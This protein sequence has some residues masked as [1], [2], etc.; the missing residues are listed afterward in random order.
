M[1]DLAG[2]LDIP[3]KVVARH[4]FHDFVVKL[5]QDGVQ[6]ERLAHGLNFEEA[7]SALSHATLMQ[8]M[9]ICARECFTQR[10]HLIERG[11]R[12]MNLACEAETVTNIKVVDCAI[13]NPTHLPEILPLEPYENHNWTSEQYEACF[14]ET[15]TWLSDHAPMMEICGVICDNLP[16]QVAGL[17]TFLETADGKCSAILHI[18]CVNHMVNLVFTHTIKNGIF[19]EVPAT[20]PEVIRILHSALVFDVMGVRCPRLI[21]TMGGC[22]VDVLAFLTDHS[23]RSKPP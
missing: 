17:R 2:K 9:F 21:Q 8:A 3:T 18:P 7:V 1:V 14:R 19:S 20:L 13:V 22:L 23:P 6:A 4:A 12:S 10:L 16:A 5:M 15:V 11:Q